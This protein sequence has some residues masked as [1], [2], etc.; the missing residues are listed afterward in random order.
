MDATSS[1]R[2]EIEEVLQE[3]W[4]GYGQILR[5]KLTGSPYQTVVAKFI[6]L[7]E[8]GNHPRGWNTNIS[9][10]RKVKSY[11]IEKYWYEH[12][13]DQ[14]DHCRTP[15]L[16]AS[17]HRGGQILIL[18]EDLDSSGYPLRLT[19]I[20]I[21][22]ARLCLQWLAEFHACFLHEGDIGES[23]LTGL[24]EIGSYWHLNTR[25]DELTALKDESLKEVAPSIDRALS[26]ARFQTI[27][28]GDAKLAN[29][30]FSEDVSQVAAVDFQYVG[31]GC[32]MKDV[33]YFLGSCFDEATLNA[34]DEGLLD[35]YFYFLNQSLHSRQSTIN[36]TELISEWR[37]LYPVA[38]TDFYRFLKGW[39]PTHWKINHYNEL[40]AQEVIARFQ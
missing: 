39:S 26:N 40:I 4:S 12:Y 33:A 1:T 24:W 31:G 14:C 20:S 38:C 2:F 36:S 23:K 8:S 13:N 10:E 22:E 25:L 11:E 15:R 5:I 29:F 37:D 18:L 7:S 28:H 35:T 16:L 21:E 6:N 19:S 32:G 3:L 17:M 9:H 34:N 27:V 30:C